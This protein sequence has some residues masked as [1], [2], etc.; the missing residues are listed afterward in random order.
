MVFDGCAPS[1][2]R[3]NGYVPS[4]KSN[5]NHGLLR[6]SS[7]S[8]KCIKLWK[9]K[10]KIGRR[11]CWGETEAV[12]EIIYICYESWRKE[13]WTTIQEAEYLSICFQRDI[14]WHHVAGAEQ[15][16]VNRNGKGMLSLMPTFCFQVR[17]QARRPT[18]LLFSSGRR[19]V[20]ICC[21]NLQPINSHTGT[22]SN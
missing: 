11:C 16:Q 10:G 22:W 13:T 5:R 4:L 1:V 19:R 20:L 14:F 12:K 8:T 15:A 2:R 7:S 3:W 6:M 18:I 17:L 9:W 21:C